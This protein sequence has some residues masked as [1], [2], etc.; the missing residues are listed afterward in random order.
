[1]KWGEPIKTGGECPDWLKP[2]EPLAYTNAFGEWA[3]RAITDN[4]DCR[5]WYWEHI[6]QIKL[7]IGHWIYEKPLENPADWAI[8]KAS[9]LISDSPER[10]FETKAEMAFAR[11][12]ERHETP[13]VD[14][15][16]LAVQEILTAW[17]GPQHFHIPAENAAY[18]TDIPVDFQAAL[19]AYRRH[20]NV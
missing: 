14:P 3:E 18:L 4:T 9:R 10:Y 13:P 11:Y 6:G 1:M 20:R 17:V 7:P 12:I 8:E 16:V 5:Q 2:D 19:A 15:D